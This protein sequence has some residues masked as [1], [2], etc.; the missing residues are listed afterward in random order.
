MAT[1][2]ERSRC[3]AARYRVASGGDRLSNCRSVA[4]RTVSAWSICDANIR[5]QARAKPCWMSCREAGLCELQKE[6]AASPLDSRLQ[7]SGI[8]SSFSSYR[9]E[10]TGHHDEAGPVGGTFAVDLV[11]ASSL[12]R[13][14]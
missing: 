1:T 11:P 2:A 8:F 5:H 14:N 9:L 12:V 13:L 3:D 7:P 6:N 4:S 10:P